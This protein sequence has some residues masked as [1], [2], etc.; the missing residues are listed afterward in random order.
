VGERDGIVI[1]NSDTA[2]QGSL[3]NCKRLEIFGYVE[4]DVTT[5]ELIVHEGGNFYGQAQ[6][7]TA[8]V[9]GIV[10]GDIVVDGLIKIH[11]TGVVSGNVHYGRLAMA[12]GGN[13]SAEMRNVPPRLMG[14]FQI[15]VLRGRSTR[16][17]T[18]DITAVDPDDTSS[19]LVFTVSN[20]THGA[21]SI[22]GVAPNGSVDH[23]FTQADLAGGRVIFKHDGSTAES[24]SFD[25]IVADKSGST[26]GTPQTVKVVVRA[27]A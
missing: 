3:R 4:G 10:Q 21:V 18:D 19:D 9:S 11:P 17:T 23:K 15:S 5:G 1:I 14:D 8:D 2:F 7:T 12:S 27:A 26:S 25:V 22:T 16:I 24:A 6:T 13:L 20:Q